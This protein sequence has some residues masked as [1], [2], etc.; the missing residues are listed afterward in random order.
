MEKTLKFSYYIKKKIE[1]MDEAIN[2]QAGA[3]YQDYSYSELAKT[4]EYF[5]KKAKK[6]GLV[7][8]FKENGIL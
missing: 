4:Q 1:I 7:K 5:Y 6:Y 8:E 3:C 2:W